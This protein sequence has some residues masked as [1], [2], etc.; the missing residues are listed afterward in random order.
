MQSAFAAVRRNPRNA[1]ANGRLGMILH[2][3]ERHPSAVTAYQRA[4][5]LDPESFKWTYLPG[6][7]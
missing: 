4:H 2:P 7:G 3:Y 1:E 6:S 5:L